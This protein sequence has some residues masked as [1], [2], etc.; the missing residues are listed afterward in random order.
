MIQKKPASRLCEKCYAV[1]TWRRT[2]GAAFCSECKSSYPVKVVPKTKKDGSQ[3]YKDG[4]PEF[5]RVPYSKSEFLH[6]L[7]QYERSNYYL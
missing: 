4:K 5:N 6:W 2:H 3:I 1:F 7:K